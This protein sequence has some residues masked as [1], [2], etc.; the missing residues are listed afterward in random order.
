[1]GVCDGPGVTAGPGV[2]SSGSIGFMHLRGLDINLLV[3]LDAL[4][5]ERSITRAAEQLRLSQSGMST[6]LRRL[7]D[8]FHD[9]L[10]V[11]IGRNMVLTPLGESLVN[12]VHTIILQAKSLIDHSPGFDP[13][14]T[15]RQITIMASDYVGVVFLPDLLKRLQVAAPGISVDLVLQEDHLHGP[16]DRGEVDILIVPRQALSPDH[17]SARLFEDEYVC[18]VWDESRE[19]NDELTFEHY[20]TSHHVITRLG[21]ARAPAFDSWLFQKFDRQRI[22]DVVTMNFTLVP[23]YVVGTNRIATVHARMAKIY[24]KL[25]PLRIVPTPFEIPRIVEFIQW[26]R[27]SDKHPVTV[28][29]RDLMV[30]VGCSLGEPD[31]S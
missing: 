22:V 26:H 19:F 21:K 4:M 31:R 14:T 18:I 25:F 6:A 30:E 13:K 16:L 20:M 24:A 11:P 17:P 28:W 15:E 8:F 27:Y 29:L 10:L 3:A 12:P 1:M 5:K 2:D 9:P 7:R 23:H